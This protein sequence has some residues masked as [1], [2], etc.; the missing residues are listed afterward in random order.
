MTFRN[1]FLVHKLVIWGTKSECLIGNLE[2]TSPCSSKEISF[3]FLIVE[4]YHI[5][6]NVSV[7]WIVKKWM[8]GGYVNLAVVNSFIMQNCSS[9]S[10]T[11]MFS[12][13]FQI[14]AAYPK[15][16]SQ[17]PPPSHLPP[18]TPAPSPP[19]PQQLPNPATPSTRRA[20]FDTRVIACTAAMDAAVR[21]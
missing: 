19:S 18:P 15:D 2:G 11:F 1:L 17:L 5:Q 21:K 10:L 6:R 9:A 4:S 7:T 13:N 14:H 12:P 16:G 8:I 20:Q 3:F